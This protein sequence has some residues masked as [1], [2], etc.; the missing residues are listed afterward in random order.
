MNKE[1]KNKFN[2]SEHDCQNCSEF[3]ACPIRHTA[4]LFKDNE[5]EFN[6]VTELLENNVLELMN[7]ELMQVASI[8]NPKRVLDMLLVNAYAIG[9]EAG[10]K[11]VEGKK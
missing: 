5:N 8:T 1:R 11:S 3:S 4:M 7:D 2:P 10:V 9:H 6:R